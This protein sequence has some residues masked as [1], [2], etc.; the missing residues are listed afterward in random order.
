M[1]VLRYL[2]ASAEF[3]GVQL[4]L[5]KTNYNGGGGGIGYL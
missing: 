1:L 2:D 3:S 5:D 4:Q